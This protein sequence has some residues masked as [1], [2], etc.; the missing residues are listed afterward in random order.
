MNEL[1]QVSHYFFGVTVD[2]IK[3]HQV[4]YSEQRP[5]FHFSIELEDDE[6]TII[7]PRSKPFHSFIIGKKVRSIVLFRVT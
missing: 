3:W 5:Y 6:S 7:E 4:F 2:N 1:S